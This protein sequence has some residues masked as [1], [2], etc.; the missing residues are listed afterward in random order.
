FGA[1]QIGVMEHVVSDNP[2]FAVQLLSR[3]RDVGASTWLVDFA[4]RTTALPHL[5]RLAIDGVRFDEALTSVAVSDARQ[6]KVLAAFIETV[7]ALDARAMVGGVGTLEEADA[8]HKL[9]ASFAV[10]PAFGRL[11]SAQ[12]ASNLVVSPQAA[13][14]E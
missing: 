13:A 8:F 3:L 11:L 10:G 14:A 1:L 7:T 5:H 4:R 9:G 2:E 6:R 12:A